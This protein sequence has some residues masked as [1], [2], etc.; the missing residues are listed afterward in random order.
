MIV[1]IAVNMI[2]TEVKIDFNNLP[3]VDSDMSKLKKANPIKIKIPNQTFI[4]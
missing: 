3:N 4:N 1:T 2:R